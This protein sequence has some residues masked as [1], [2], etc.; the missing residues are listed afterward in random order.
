VNKR[1]LSLSVLTFASAMLAASAASAQGSGTDSATDN[2]AV[3]AT[4]TSKKP[5]EVSA[6]FSSSYTPEKDKA[7]EKKPT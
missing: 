1:S 2:S 6:L 3:T 7:S 5:E 4:D